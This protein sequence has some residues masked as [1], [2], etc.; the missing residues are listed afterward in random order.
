MMRP[1]M[2]DNEI[3]DR[4]E[5]HDMKHLL[6]TANAAEAENADHRLGCAQQMASVPQQRGQGDCDADECIATIA[7]GERVRLLRVDVIEM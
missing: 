6:I 7:K 5:Q 4:A 3:Q 1:F 2:R